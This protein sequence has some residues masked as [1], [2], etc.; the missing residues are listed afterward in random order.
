MQ[1][2]GNDTLQSYEAIAAD[3]ARRI[4]GVER[5]P[6]DC[7]R[8]D[9][10]VGSL[11]DRSP[12]WDLGCGPGDVTSYLD[13]RG[14]DVV[15]LDFSPAMIAE[16][17]RINPTVSFQLGD[18]THLETGDESLAGIVAFYSLIHLPPA[19]LARALD[20]FY[21]ALRPNGAL[22]IALHAGE[23]VNR[24]Q[25]WLGK[26]VRLDGY[27]YDTLRLSDALQAA[28]FSIDAIHSREPYP[29]I[30]YP[31]QRLYATARRPR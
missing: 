31:S 11:A 29:E 4:A 30:E 9:E 1:S 14:V 25:E 7:A 13:K 23:G 27:F 19:A 26:A 10:F 21:R 12:V 20:G 24:V 16:A 22:L 18:L 3:Y 17:R 5:K 6:F 8:L 15:G 28:G 2:D